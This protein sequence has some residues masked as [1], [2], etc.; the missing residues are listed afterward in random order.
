[1]FFI[2]VKVDNEG[3]ISISKN[4][5]DNDRTK[6]IDVQYH[7]TRENVELGKVAF[8]YRPTGDIVADTLAKRLLRVQFEQFRKEFGIQENNKIPSAVEC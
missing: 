6:H 2:Q 4:T 5:V 7:F 8:N 1:M 3:V